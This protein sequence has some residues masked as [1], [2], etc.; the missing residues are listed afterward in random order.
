MKSTCV[1]TSQRITVDKT[2]HFRVRTWYRSTCHVT[3]SSRSFGRYRRPNFPDGRPSVR[4]MSAVKSFEPR[5]S[6]EPTPYASTGTP[7]PSNER[8]F[9]ASKPPETTIFTRSK[10]R[11]EEHTSELQSRR[12]L[13]CRLLLEKK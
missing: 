9:S 3:R 12:D 13:V 1:S 11:S 4:T 10:P 5:I 8:I 2:S 7:C 6:D